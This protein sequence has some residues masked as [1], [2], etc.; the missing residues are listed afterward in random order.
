[1]LCLCDSVLYKKKNNN[2]KQTYTEESSLDI[3]MVLCWNEM[4]EFGVVGQ[5]SN[6]KVLIYTIVCIQKP[7]NPATKQSPAFRRRLMALGR[8][9]LPYMSHPVQS[10]HQPG[11]GEALLYWPVHS[12]ER[13]IPSVSLQTL[14]LK[15]AVCLSSRTEVEKTHR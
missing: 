4:V 14:A 10:C 6:I 11:A 13:S 15:G 9:C 12:S 5:D 7:F 2:K 8:L 3:L 1:M